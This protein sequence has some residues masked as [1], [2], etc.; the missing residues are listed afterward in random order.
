MPTVTELLDFEEAWPRWSGRKEEA[1][2][3]RFGFS[4]ARYFRLLNHA[5]DTPAA[6]AARPML[7]RRLL[8]RREAG[9]RE[10][11]RRAG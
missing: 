1:L 2:R 11:R 8:R 3:A 7:V 4:P 9:S 6:L 5:I 10:Q